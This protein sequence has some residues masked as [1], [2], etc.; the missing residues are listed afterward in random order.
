MIAID[1]PIKEWLGN[2]KKGIEKR[3]KEQEIWYNVYDG[4]VKV[5]D[6]IADGFEKQD[7]KKE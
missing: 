4:G 2:Y 7:I 3:A 6:V 1:R 5:S